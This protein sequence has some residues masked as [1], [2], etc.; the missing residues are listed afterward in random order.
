MAAWLQAYARSALRVSALFDATFAGMAT[1]STYAIS[2]QDLAGTTVVVSR[3]WNTD[4]LAVELALSEPLVEGIAYVLTASGVTGSAVAVHQAV[5]VQV[6]GPDV[7]D[8]DDPEAEAFGD[9]IDWLGAQLGPDGDAPRLRG[10]ECLRRDLV[11]R[12]LTRRG[13]L[14]HRPTVGAGL[15][16]RVNGP[17]TDAELA[18]LSAALKREWADD[19]RVRGVAVQSTASTSGAVTADAQVRT[20]AL[21]DPIQ[22]VVRR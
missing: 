18:E 8:A 16:M 13:E 20:I 2:R 22:V 15:T 14:F 10:L 7:D 19:D 9:D 3:A 11:A 1:A 12:A 17:N 4:T 21:E 5:A 6:I